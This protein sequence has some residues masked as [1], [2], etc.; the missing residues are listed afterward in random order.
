MS[1]WSLVY[2]VNSARLYRFPQN[3]CLTVKQWSGNLNVTNE[4][5]I[6]L[7]NSR[8]TAMFKFHN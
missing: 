5:I 3:D 8:T 6:Q 1:D 7:W 4:P 2:F